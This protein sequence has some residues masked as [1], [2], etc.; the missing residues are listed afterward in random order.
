VD[1]NRWRREVNRQCGGGGRR[2][3][4]VVKSAGTYG[5]EPLPLRGNETRKK[6]AIESEGTMGSV[7]PSP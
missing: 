6:K 2:G 1:T 3:R 7:L 5:G 4:D